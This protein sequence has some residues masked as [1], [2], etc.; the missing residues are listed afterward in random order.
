MGERQFSRSP[1]EGSQVSPSA[2]VKLAS[3]CLTAIAGGGAH[4]TRRRRE[5]PAQSARFANE[6]A[7]APARAADGRFEAGA[8]AGCG[9]CPQRIDHATI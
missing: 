3:E 7:S 9:S 5:K 8:K 2:G 1:Y 4:S 6:A